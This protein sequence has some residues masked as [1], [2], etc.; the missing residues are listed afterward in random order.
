M[1]AVDTIVTRSIQPDDA[2]RFLSLM[3]TNASPC[4]CRYWE[5]SGD[6]NAWLARCAEAPD[7]TR[8]EAQTAIAR[9]DKT[10][11]GVVALQGSQ[12]IGWCKVSVQANKIFTLSVYRRDAARFQDAETAVLGCFYVHPSYRRKGVA[13]RLLAEAIPYSRSL[14]A[15]RLL[16]LPRRAPPI[17]HDEEA[18]FGIESMFVRA[19]FEEQTEGA[20]PVL[21][22]SL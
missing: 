12:L 17:V 9:A 10:A 16:A 7:A 1:S 11:Q 21:S 8:S 4:Y 2:T 3:E 15:K 5:F 19:G 13:E 22:L 6:K 18:Q 20:H 14:G